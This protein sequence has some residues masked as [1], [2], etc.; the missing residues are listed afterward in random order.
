MEKAEFIEFDLIRNSL[1]I[2][3]NLFNIYL[4]EVYSDLSQRPDSDK[5]KGISKITFCEYL[6]LPVF[7]SHK[8]F[9]SLDKDNDIFLNFKEFSFGMVKLFAGN[10][11]ETAQII[12]CIFDFDK[13]GIIKKGDVKL[14]LSYLPLKSTSHKNTNHKNQMESLDELDEILNET[15]GENIDSLNFEQY[16]NKIEN[17]KSDIYFQ[18]LCFFY[19][20]KPFEESSINQYKKLKSNKSDS[21]SSPVKVG[22]KSFIEV[23]P[24]N[25]NV[26]SSKRFPSPSKKT[27]FL[28]AE[29]YLHLSLLRTNSFEKDKNS[30][31]SQV[32]SPASKGSNDPRLGVTTSNFKITL[33]STSGNN[34]SPKKQNNYGAQTA[35]AP[36]KTMSRLKLNEKEDEVIRMPN[37]KVNKDINMP[38]KSDYDQLLKQSKNYYDSPSFILKEAKKLEKKVSLININENSENLINLTSTDIESVQVNSYEDWVYVQE[39]DAKLKKLFTVLNGK[40]LT[41]YK[42]NLKDELVSLQ[43]LSGCFIK[44]L[45]NETK[46]FDKE[47]FYG[48]SLMH[49]KDKNKILYTQKIE[50]KNDWVESIKK[51]IGYEHFTDFYDVSSTL[52]EGLFGVV[53]KGIHLKTN[54]IVA[55]KIIS[56]DKLR[57]GEIDLIRTE[58]DLMKLFQHPNIVKLIDHYENSESI[59]IVMEYLEGGTLMDYL[60]Y[61][62]LK[63][64][65]KL[66]AKITYC[67]ASVIKYL[68]SYGVIHR[69]LK[70]ENIM[71]TDKT[72]NPRIKIIDFGLTR[73]LAPG[74][75][76]AEGFGTITY[77]APE[78]LTR[79]P[80]NK[81]IDIW[82]LGVI[83][84][85]LL[86]GGKLPFDDE[87]NNEELIAKKAVLMDPPFPQEYFSSR[88]KNLI[89]LISDCLIKDPD[90]RITIDKFIK[91]EW[92]KANY[93][94]KENE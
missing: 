2:Q 8:F 5:D 71:L 31:D 45:G 88:P 84:Y 53:K 24:M 70:P 46:T 9:S 59:Y 90:K 82:S 94:P 39:K 28:P 89:N 42:S 78:V 29:K 43:N 22:K 69:D 36:K 79:K 26:A 3:I 92:L 32:D 25:L 81:Q 21:N 68:N 93:I 41:F 52:G 12:F 30:S 73:T 74:E 51:S 19:G 15:F 10:F 80:Y 72:D 47:K 76:L 34:E 66:I 44:D 61:K 62:D 54:E 38:G 17:K 40:E 83:L 1:N 7:I 57:P 33:T 55:V 91:S 64:N 27:K 13:D 49:S 67:V 87:N 75:K 20:K 63:L 23:Q 58:I 14:L 35:M 37:R 85:F 18:L 48:F 4:K 11:E 56:K 65:D 16:L 60:E 6:K 86:T 50:K 77:V